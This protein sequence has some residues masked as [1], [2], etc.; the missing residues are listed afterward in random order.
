MVAS[1][2]HVN[3]PVGSI[4]VG[5]FFLA[6]NPASFSRRT[7]LNVVR[8]TGSYVSPRADMDILA[9]FK[10]LCHPAH[11]KQNVQIQCFI[12]TGL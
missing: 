8:Q 4:K 2:K 11:N 7:L 5:D 12:R 3:E 1:Y 10:I 9:K 6:E